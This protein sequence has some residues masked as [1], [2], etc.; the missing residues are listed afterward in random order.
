MFDLVNRDF[1][2]ITTAT[3]TTAVVDAESWGE[4]VT[5]ARQISTLSKWHPSSDY[6]VSCSLSFAAMTSFTEARDFI[7]LSYEQGLISDEEFLVLYDSY[8]PKNL[9]LPYNMYE[10][11]D[12]YEMEDDECVAEF[13]VRKRDI[14]LLGEVL[15]IPEVVIC[16]QRSIADG[17]EA[18][19]MLLKRLAYPVRYSDMVPR[20][21]RPVPVLSMITNEVL[22]HVYRTHQHRICQWYPEVM[23]PLALQR[24]AD[25]VANKGAPL[26]NCFGFIDGTV[27]PIARP[28]TNQRIV[29]NGHK[30]VHAIKFQSVTLPNGIIG[31]LYGPTGKGIFFFAF[32]LFNVNAKWTKFQTA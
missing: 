15:Q 4:Y 10:S 22:D 2:Q 24:Y 27:R 18:L 16:N 28:D 14:P 5:V 12:L 6:G 23:N 31:H 26:Q 20:F 7:V 21:A 1:K 17:T 11:F 9:D 32:G 19:C 29:Y 30:R 13:R 8:K 3:S 25:A